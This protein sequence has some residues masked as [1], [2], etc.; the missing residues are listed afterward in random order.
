MDRK[1]WGT[2]NYNKDMDFSL[3]QQS[4]PTDTYGTVPEIFNAICYYDVYL[5]SIHCRLPIIQTS[6]QLLATIQKGIS[7]EEFEKSGVPHKLDDRHGMRKSGTPT[8]IANFVHYYLDWL[9]ATNKRK[10]DSRGLN[11]SRQMLDSCVIGMY[12]NR[13]THLH[14][15]ERTER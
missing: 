13:V 5:E 6:I 12:L 9:R 7:D 3:C 11:P 10:W 4:E 1:E 8:A 2:K 15:D 14:Y